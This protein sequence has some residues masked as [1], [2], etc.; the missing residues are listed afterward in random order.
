M[1]T[2]SCSNARLPEESEIQR[3]QMQEKN[4]RALAG[5]MYACV[6][7]EAF[8]WPTIRKGANMNWSFSSH[9]E[10]KV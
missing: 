10:A 8:I 5:Q 9:F 6:L 2:K 4:Q 1:D 7:N 3:G